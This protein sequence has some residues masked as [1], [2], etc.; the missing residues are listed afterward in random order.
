M[1]R[2]APSASRSLCRAVSHLGMS[3][4]IGS[5]SIV[6]IAINRWPDRD[7]QPVIPARKIVGSSLIRQISRT[8]PIALIATENCLPRSVS[9]ALRQSPA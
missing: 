7:L 9:L 3:H 6:A 8:M 5:A 1:Q 2:D 4:G